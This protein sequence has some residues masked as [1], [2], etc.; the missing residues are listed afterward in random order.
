MASGP[1]SK[2]VRNV[3]FKIAKG[4]FQGKTKVGLAAGKAGS[5]L[6]KR[7]TSRKGGEKWGTLREMGTLRDMGHTWCG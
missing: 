3:P 6:A 7:P 2:L 1:V 4:G 5:A